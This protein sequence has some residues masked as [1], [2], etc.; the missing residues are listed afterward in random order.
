M[1][2]ETKYKLTVLA[3]PLDGPEYTYR[4]AINRHTW[5]LNTLFKTRKALKAKIKDYRE[6]VAP[7]HN[8]RL[9]ITVIETTSKVFYS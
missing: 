2:K 6:R 3:Y 7:M 1:N 8:C 5:E 4:G 9:E